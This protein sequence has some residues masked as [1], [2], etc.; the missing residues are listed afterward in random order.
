MFNWYTTY[1]PYVV[2]KKDK[3]TCGEVV[4]V[5]SKMKKKNESTS[6]AFIFL[7][8]VYK[9]KTTEDYVMMGTLDSSEKYK[10]K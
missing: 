5:S 8:I 6:C 3:R 10:S 2:W 9:T 1:M 4:V 7:F